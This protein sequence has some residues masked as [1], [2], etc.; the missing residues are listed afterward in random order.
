MNRN[1]GMVD[2]F[3]TLNNNYFLNKVTFST[4]NVR[5]PLTVSYTV[6]DKINGF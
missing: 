6:P 5:W 3:I 1:F 2:V 4:Q